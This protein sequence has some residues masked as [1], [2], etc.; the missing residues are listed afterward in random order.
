MVQYHGLGM[1]YQIRKSDKLA[2]TK[3]VSKLISSGMRS[4]YA[5]CLLVSS[6]TAKIVNIYFLKFNIVLLSM[7]AT[8]NDFVIEN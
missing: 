7:M 2:V 4:P 3:M 1:L 6:A 5:I 8:I